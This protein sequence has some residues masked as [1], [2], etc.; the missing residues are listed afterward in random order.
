MFPVGIK[1]RESAFVG[2]MV[3]SGE[4][5]FTR[6]RLP[7]ASRESRFALSRLLRFAKGTGHPHPDPLLISPRRGRW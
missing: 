5:Q 1:G 4:L 2:V 3:R 6:T 7:R